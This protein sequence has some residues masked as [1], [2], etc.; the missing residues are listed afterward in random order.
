MSK[1]LTDVITES[2]KKS[3]SLTNRL[4]VGFHLVVIALLLFLTVMAWNSSVTT[5]NLSEVLNK[6]SPVI[7]Y[8]SCYNAR[9]SANNIAV[10]E[11]VLL[12]TTADKSVPE[13]PEIQ[14]A[15][16]RLVVTGQALED[17]ND[18]SSDNPCPHIPPSK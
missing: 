9:N 1:E 17:A 8:L 18:A 5:H 14:K 10:D 4:K 6:R 12:Y 13:G 15:V 7:E 11:L 3:D 2:R 16:D